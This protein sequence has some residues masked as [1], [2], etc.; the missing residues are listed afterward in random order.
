MIQEA[1]PTKVFK[2][3]IKILTCSIHIGDYCHLYCFAY[4]LVHELAKKEMNL[5][6]HLFNNIFTC[7]KTNW[8]SFLEENLV[9]V[10]CSLSDSTTSTITS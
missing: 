5:S 7:S 1:T 6:S 8:K 4:G 9:S 2:K 3:A 10:D